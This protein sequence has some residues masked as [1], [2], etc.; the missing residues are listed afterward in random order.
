MAIKKGKIV[1]ITSVKGGVGKTTTVLNLAGILA[2]LKKKTLVIDGDL[3]NGG[4][5]TSLDIEFDKDLYLLINDMSTSHFDQLGSYVKQ[6]NEYID[7]LPA[8]NDPRNANKIE[9]K[10]LNIILAKAS[11][12][13]DVV[14]IDLNHVMD[15]SNLTFLDNAD[16]IYYVITND[17]VDIKG[18]KTMISIYSDIDKT[19]YRIILNNAKDRLKEALPKSD[20]SNVIKDNIDY[21][22]PSSF[23]LSNINSYV[24]KG[25]IIT[26]NK[27]IIRR[28]KKTMKV[29]KDIVSE[30]LNL[31]EKNGK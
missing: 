21:I 14:L 3:Y 5:A 2:S 31:G 30:I 18:I 12:Y 11:M 15:S 20:V 25:N 6:Y 13:Y 17:I 23:Y 8:S 28:H 7:I 16:L 29:Y 26:L 4:I 27:G 22:I 1:A 24:Y 9:S 19:N 10:F